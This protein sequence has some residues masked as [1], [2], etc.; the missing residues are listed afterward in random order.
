[1][2]IGTVIEVHA[3]ADLSVPARILDLFAAQNCLPYAF[4]FRCGDDGRM[5]LCIDADGTPEPRLA[6][7]LAKLSCIG[8]VYDA[9]ARADCNASC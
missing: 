3:E 9:V 1:M 4:S 8:G 7:V 2:S 5:L 6:I